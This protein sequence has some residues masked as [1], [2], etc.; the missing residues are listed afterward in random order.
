MGD[1]RD[2]ILEI[3]NEMFRHG[4]VTSTGGNISARTENNPNE[5]WITPSSIY[6]GTLTADM[7]VKVTLEGEIIGD[8][9]Y[10]ASSERRVH[11][12]IYTLRPDV[13]AVIH[14]HALYSTLMALTNTRWQPIS[15]DAAF[16]GQVPVVPFIMPGSPEL[17]DEVGKAIMPKGIAVIMQNH[18]L[19]VA[20]SSLRTAADT[21]E[22][23]E[24]TAE[25]LLYCRKLGV[26]PAVLPADVVEILSE[27]GTMVA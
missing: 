1:I 17:A 15:A 12:G 7:M 16:F 11:C 4:W 24:I 23:I 8:S 22:A 18:G 3:N 26:D 6:K 13:K 27:M 19:V 21:T 14:T 20:G 10:N 5:I 2:S 9:T 25:K